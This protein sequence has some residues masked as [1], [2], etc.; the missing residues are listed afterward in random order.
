MCVFTIHQAVVSGGQLY[1]ATSTLAAD[2]SSPSYMRR[3]AI[4]W[5]QLSVNP[6]S[7]GADSCQQS[8]T[9]VA[10]RQ[11]W[12]WATDYSKQW[13]AAPSTPSPAASAQGSGDRVVRAA[14][15]LPLIG[16]AQFAAVGLTQLGGWLG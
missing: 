13:G 10:S 5:A 8:R 2:K 6:T 11:A 14:N 15:L 3:P 9:G 16:A 1:L 7:Q 12:D 4:V